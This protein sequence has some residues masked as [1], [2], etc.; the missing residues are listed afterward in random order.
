MVSRLCLSWLCVVRRLFG[1]RVY[2]FA[3]CITASKEPGTSRHNAFL[4]AALHRSHSAGFSVDF[5]LK[6]I[7]SARLPRPAI[8][9]G[10]LERILMAM[11]SDLL[12]KNMNYGG[13]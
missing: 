10:M 4:M 6:L 13:Y 8:C 7:Q 1:L 5:K 2:N 9:L 3:K 12:F 11:L